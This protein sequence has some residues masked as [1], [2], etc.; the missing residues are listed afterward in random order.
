[1]PSSPPC[2]GSRFLME[3]CVPRRQPCLEGDSLLRVP[4]VPHRSCLVS[5]LCFWTRQVAPCRVVLNIFDE[6][7]YQ[8]WTS[9][10]KFCRVS[11]VSRNG[12]DHVVQSNGL[13]IR[14][15]YHHQAS[16]GCAVVWTGSSFLGDG[17]KANRASPGLGPGCDAL[18]HGSSH[19]GK[20]PVPT[21]SGRRK[22]TTCPKVRPEATTT[23]TKAHSN[24]TPEPWSLLWPSLRRWDRVVLYLDPDLHLAVCMR[25]ACCSRNGDKDWPEFFSGRVLKTL[26]MVCP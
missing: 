13:T 11:V 9:L 3:S 19:D 10:V 24:S 1:M 7:I 2:V 12:Q 25:Y 4:L 14:G 17:L 5:S 6:L 22:P 21:S 23:T 15:A 8:H 18:S 26:L 20:Y 16:S